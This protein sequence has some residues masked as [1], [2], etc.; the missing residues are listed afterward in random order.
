MNAIQDFT[1]VPTL[2]L[3]SST[4]VHLSSSTPCLT[5]GQVGDDR[6]IRLSWSRKIDSGACPLTNFNRSPCHACSPSSPVA[7]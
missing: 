2:P 5:Q 3:P 1:L 6:L 4:S 7:Q